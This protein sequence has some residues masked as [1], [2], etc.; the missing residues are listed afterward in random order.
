MQFRRTKSKLRV[1][2][3]IFGATQRSIQEAIKKLLYKSAS[4]DPRLGPLRNQYEALPAV[5]RSWG[6]RERTWDEITRALLHTS[7]VLGA[8]SSLTEPQVYF[9]NAEGQLVIGDGCAEPAEETLGLNYAAS[10]SQARRISY[11]GPDGK[12]RVTEDSAKILPGTPVL[13]ERGLITLAEYGR[14]NKGQFERQEMT[15]I[16]SSDIA[17]SLVRAGFWRLGKLYVA[18]YTKEG[19]SVRGS[20]RVVRINL[21]FES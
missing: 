17:N 3:V 11:L 6:G 20:R 2:A 15:W 4:E 9:L 21:A 19:N 10:H 8:V 12:S 16:E 7:D 5:D 18:R 1:E 13:C 14:I